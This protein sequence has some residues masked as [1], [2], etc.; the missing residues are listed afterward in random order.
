LSVAGVAKGA[1][2][3]VALT[4]KTSPGAAAAGA[5]AAANATAAENFRAI[6]GFLRQIEVTIDLPCLK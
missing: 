2:S 4:W 6:E 5:E 3:S 1:G